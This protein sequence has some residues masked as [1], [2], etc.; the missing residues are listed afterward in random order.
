MMAGCLIVQQHSFLACR[1][2]PNRLEPAGSTSTA[3]Q[4]VGVRQSSAE[5]DIGGLAL[6]NALLDLYAAVRAAAAPGGA[7]GGSQGGGCRGENS[8]GAGAGED[9]ASGAEE[10]AWPWFP[11]MGG[12]AG[13]WDWGSG[14]WAEGGEGLEDWAL[15]LDPD[16]SARAQGGMP[17]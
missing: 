7:G 3:G 2:A 1:A 17:N 6:R 13:G 10:E 16:R 15:L 14:L 4:G 9:G 11:D 8:A 12:Q 5:S